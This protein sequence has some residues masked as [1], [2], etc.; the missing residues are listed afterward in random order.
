MR[1]QA[2]LSKELRAEDA[3]ATGPLHENGLLNASMVSVQRFHAV[4]AGRSSDFGL[5]TLLPFAIFIE[6]VRWLAPRNF[7][8]HY[9]CATALDSHQLPV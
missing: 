6:T 7:S 3:V 2:P 8:S 4:V 9:R 5:P 1:R